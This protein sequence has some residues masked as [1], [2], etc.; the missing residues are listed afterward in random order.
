MT[1][2]RSTDHR[3]TV[4]LAGEVVELSPPTL[5]GDGP[6]QTTFGRVADIEV[7]TNRYLHRRVGAFRWRSDTWWLHNLGSAIVLEVADLASASRVSVAPGAAVPLS[8]ARSIVRFQAGPSTYE[9]VLTQAAVTAPAEAWV[10]DDDDDD[11]DEPTVTS[12]SVPLNREQRLLLAG[13]AQRRL[14]DPGAPV[15]SLATNR[16]VTEHLG[17]T[18]TKFD[19]KLDNLCVKFANR[20]VPGLVGGQGSTAALRRERLIDHVLV[21]GLIGPDDLGD[22]EVAGA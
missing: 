10:D 17:W 13:L 18:K 4:D 8:F 12:S 1:A 16:E 14:R 3:L 21:V 9:L 7:D 6:M 2:H 22:Y 20:G 15:S 19:R 11:D 5:D